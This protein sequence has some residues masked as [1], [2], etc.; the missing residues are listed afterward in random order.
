MIKNKIT[1][2]EIIELYDGVYTKEYDKNLK[3]FGVKKISRPNLNKTSQAS[4]VLLYL[5]KYIGDVISKKEL[6][7][8]YQLI[9][10]T[11]TTDLQSGRHLGTQFGYDIINNRG[12]INGYCLKS[13]KVR[14]GFLP[15][16][17]DVDMTKLEWENLKKDY[18]YKCASCGDTEGKPTRYDANKISKLEMGHMN[19][20]KSLTLSNTIPQC[21]ECNSQYKDK[22]IFNKLGRITGNAK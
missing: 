11:N 16:R 8:Q 1:I 12:N 3:R 22:Y 4:F 18:N 10:N 2:D 6:T 5:L 9:S 20:S 15:N 7:E 19:P 14:G 17:R 21:S 13:L